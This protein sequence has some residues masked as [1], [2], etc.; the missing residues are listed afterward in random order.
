MTALVTGGAGLVGSALCRRLMDA[1]AQVLCVDDFSLGTPRHIEEFA[2]RAAFEFEKWDVSRPGWHEK[3]KGR[4]FDL[5]VHL[6]ANSDISRGRESPEM[7]KDRTFATTF[8]ALQAARALRIPNFLFA[9]TSAVYGADPAMPTP[10]SAPNLHPVSVYG[11]GK[12]ASEAYVSAFV[13]NYG[14]QAWVF[15][16]GNVVGRKLTHGAIFDFVARLRANPAELVVL[17]DGRQ[18]KTYIDVEDCAAG[19]VRG[20]EKSPAGRTHA[21]RFQV[22][23]L[24]T[25]GTTTVRE[26]AEEASAVVAGGK[27]AIRYGTA[28]IGWVGDVPKTSLDV[29]RIRALGWEPK[30]DSTAAVAASIRA[31][32]DWSK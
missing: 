22:F 20:F 27:A 18:T 8:E 28:P 15:R 26:I 29:S 10:E 9:S 3:L 17:G 13:E 16:F 1:G 25:T 23:N 19:I 30:L 14:L 32:A 24:S 31:Y 2:S 6:A 5:L 12:L 11:A 7:D 21:Q 4:R